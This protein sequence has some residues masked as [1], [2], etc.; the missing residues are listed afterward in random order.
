MVAPDIQRLSAADVDFDASGGISDTP[1]TPG[2]SANGNSKSSVNQNVPRS[3]SAGNVSRLVIPRPQLH[4][5]TKSSTS[6]KGFPA[7]GNNSVSPR[8]STR[9]MELRHDEEKSRPSP[10]IR[11]VPTQPNDKSRLVNQF[12]NAI[13]DMNK[14]RSSSN[15]N[16]VAD[17]RQ[18]LARSGALSGEANHRP[19]IETELSEDHFDR[20][21]NSGGYEYTP[22]DNSVGLDDKLVHHL[23]NIDT[24]LGNEHS[25]EAGLQPL[26]DILDSISER[27]LS[28]TRHSILSDPITPTILVEL[29]MLQKYL[30]QLHLSVETLL[31]ESIH[32][33]DETKGHYRQEISTNIAKLSDLVQTLDTLESR[34]NA[35]RQLINTNKAQITDEFSAKVETLEYVHKRYREYSQKVHNRRFVQ[36]T[37]AVGIVILVI[38]I[39]A[40]L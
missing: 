10:V 16:S 34:L 7:A 11:S 8:K 23:L 20:I 13:N 6:A 9:A 2:K 19:S 39:Y 5:R 15:N 14:S 22:M 40:V 1:A 25:S 28:Q 18:L 17:M 21:I 33:K 27:F 32:N 38:S 29:S 24:I 12:Y 36:L 30:R 3:S 37:S 4:V 31:T 26:R 35:S